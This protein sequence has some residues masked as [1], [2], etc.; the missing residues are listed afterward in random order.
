M[1]WSAHVKYLQS[2]FKEF[3]NATAPIDNFLIRYFWDGMKPSIQAQMHKK[4]RDFDD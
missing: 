1:N 3:D 2:V 4:D